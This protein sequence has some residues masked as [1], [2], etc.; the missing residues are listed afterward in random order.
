MNNS[1]PRLIDGVCQ[2]LRAEVLSRIDDEYARSQIY[3]V[4]NLLNTFKVRADWSTGFLLQQIEV[5]LQA[6]QATAEQLPRAA[7]AQPPLP[8]LPVAATVAELLALRDDCNH[9]I[10]QWLHDLDAV[11]EPI[12]PAQAQAVEALLCQAM[13]KETEIELRHSPRPMF[14]EMS[15]QDEAGAPAGDAQS[16]GTTTT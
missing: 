5:Q 10:G 6:L 8:A 11:R 4:I 13:R 2:T 12:D 1:F 15:G 7:A 14:A 9:R 16:A 3:G